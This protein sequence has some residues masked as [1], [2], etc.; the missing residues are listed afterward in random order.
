MTNFD[1][2][3]N[4]LDILRIL[5]ALP[6]GFFTFLIPINDIAPEEFK[7]YENRIIKILLFFNRNIK[8]TSTFVSKFL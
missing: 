2:S 4:C 5:W 8:R 1:N 3:E 6:Y 7:E